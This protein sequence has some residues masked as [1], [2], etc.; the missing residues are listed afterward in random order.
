METIQQKRERLIRELEAETKD[1]L[2][3]AKKI[4]LKRFEQDNGLI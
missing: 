3:L 4:Y 1:N 2:I